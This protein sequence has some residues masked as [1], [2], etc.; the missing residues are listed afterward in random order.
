MN[1]VICFSSV[2]Y[3]TIAAVITKKEKSLGENII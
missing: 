1:S 2:E 3:S